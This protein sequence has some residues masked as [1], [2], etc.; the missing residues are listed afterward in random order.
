MITEYVAHVKQQTDGRWDT[1]LLEEHLYA[2]ADLAEKFAQSF[3][4][5]DWAYLAGLWHDLGKYRPAFQ[6]HIRKSSGYEPDA[7]I[8]MGSGRTMHMWDRTE[9]MHGVGPK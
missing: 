5:E 6:D 8:G 4:S 1:H 7:H 3:D 9:W 2:V